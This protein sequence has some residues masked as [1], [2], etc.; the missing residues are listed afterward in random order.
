MAQPPDLTDVW[1]IRPKLRHDVVILEATAGAYLRGPDTAFLL[2]GRTA[3]R[4]LST[5]VPYL[6][7]EHSVA[8][9]CA[10]L[11]AGQRQTVASLIRA[12]TSRGFAKNAVGAGGLPAPVADHF[13]RQVEFIDHFADD[14]ATRFRRFRDAYVA[15]GGAGPTLL[16]AATGLLRNG[17]ARISLHPEDDPEPYRAAL[18]EETERLDA[19]G[20]PASVRIETG[21]LDGLHRATAAD[22][23]GASVPGADGPVAAGPGANGRGTAGADGG[24]TTA[25][26]YCADTAGLPRV[27]ELARRY[28]AAGP[29]FVPVVWQGGRGVLGPVTGA[30]AAPCWLCAQLRLS[31]SA[32]PAV[33]ARTWRHLA[34]GAVGGAD[35]DPVDE[36]PARM[37]GNAAAFEVFRALTGALPADASAAVV[38]LDLDTLESTRERVLRHPECP[39]CRHHPVATEQ[40]LPAP[41]TDEEAYQ[42]AEILVSPNTGVFT[43]FID[44]PLEQ[45]PLKTARLRVP[46]DAGPRDI[47]TFDVGTVLG[48]RLAAYRVAIR[49]YLS[50][51]DVPPDGAVTATADEL[52]AAGRE[53]VPWTELDTYRGAAPYD[54][55]RRLS[56]LPARVLGGAGEATVWVPAAMVTRFGPA[57]RDGLAERT[58]AGAAV[59]P[60]VDAVTADGLAGALAYRALVELTRGRGELTPVPEAALVVDEETALVLKAAHRF[61]RVVRAYELVGAA[62]VAAVLAIE[63]PA[64]DGR[65]LWTVAAGT[66]VRSA[67]LAALRDLVGAMQVRHFEGTAADPGDPLLDDLDPRT[68]L[69]PDGGAGRDPAGGSFDGAS[70]DGADVA[71]PEILASLAARGLTALLV[72]HN[73]PDI[74]ASQALTAGVVLLR[75]SSD[76]PPDPR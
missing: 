31:A 26:V 62:P 18:R 75:R 35:A 47:T 9:M 65:P 16:A 61:G 3:Y 15:L 55:G 28:H 20:V 32:A 29:I 1:D 70:P 46:T 22:G 37:L 38:L 59:G 21:G 5:L 48:A 42:R 27:L 34:L 74:R 66:S 60:T 69:P 39:I 45:A 63:E 76:A 4:W 36:I 13:A 40:P 43:R 57:N 10:G 51:R 11:D 50:R 7:G 73:T 44:D 2:K 54:P 71:V 53:P 12:L 24:T 33:A 19:A 64:D 17:C 67:R 14:A 52:R 30:G 56:W 25:I 72:E 58:V 8:Q 6:D 41:T 49:D 68:L 23:P